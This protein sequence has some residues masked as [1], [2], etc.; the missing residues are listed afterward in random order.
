MHPQNEIKENPLKIM[1]QID[2]YDWDIARQT[3]YVDVLKRQFKNQTISLWGELNEFFLD[4]MYLFQGHALQQI[5]N[6]SCKENFKILVKDSSIL[7]LGKKKV[8]RYN[9]LMI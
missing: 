3:W 5:C 1:N 8:N 6:S 2:I 4:N 9:L 7:Y